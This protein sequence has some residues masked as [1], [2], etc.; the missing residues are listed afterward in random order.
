MQT[1]NP[2]PSLTSSPGTPSNLHNDKMVAVWERL[3]KHIKANVPTYIMVSMIIGIHFGWQI[4]QSNP[5]LVKPQEKRD[6]PI[7]QAVH[8]LQAKVESSLPSS[9]EKKSD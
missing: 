6:L 1:T 5:V 7:L 2:K 9:V 4:L 8:Q 3:R